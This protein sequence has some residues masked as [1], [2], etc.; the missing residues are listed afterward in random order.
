M[1][2]KH[3]VKLPSDLIEETIDWAKVAARDDRFKNKYSSHGAEN[4]HTVLFTSKLSE[5]AFAQWAGLDRDAVALD[6][7]DPDYDV[8]IGDH[9]I[10]VKSCV[11]EH[12]LLCWPATKVTK[13]VPANFTHLV[14]VKFDLPEF[15]IAGWI[16]KE[17]FRRERLVATDEDNKFGL[18][19]GTRYI[20][21]DNLESM[22]L[23]PRQV[24]EAAP[25][26]DP[27]QKESEHFLHYCHCGQWGAW[28]YGVDY[29]R[30]KSGDWYCFAHRPLNKVAA[31]LT[32]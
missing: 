19:I 5:Y 28:G 1:G 2:L 17:R 20:H 11:L 32:K 31:T 6:D 29:R 16:T 26:I 22:D 3:L 7:F 27:N 10:D 23:F 21:Q 8:I 18:D 9:F 13:F 30:G 14:L 12:S 15:I 24:V 4:N 25:V